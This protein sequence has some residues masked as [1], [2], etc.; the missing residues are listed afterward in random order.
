MIQVSSQHLAWC[1]TTAE[2]ATTCFCDNHALNDRPLSGSARV[3][4]RAE[5]RPGGE[6]PANDWALRHRPTPSLSAFGSFQAKR[7]FSPL[8]TVQNKYCTRQNTWIY[9]DGHY[10]LSTFGVFYVFVSD[11]LFLCNEINV[12]YVQL[13]ERGAGSQDAIE[14]MKRDIFVRQESCIYWTP[15][16]LI[17]FHHGI[18][19]MKGVRMDLPIHYY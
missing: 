6:L 11:P 9:N 7:G 2:R 15:S 5:S 3:S 16:S 1:Y 4:T 19:P 13:Y 14:C 17:V 12:R 18:N 10:P 8:E